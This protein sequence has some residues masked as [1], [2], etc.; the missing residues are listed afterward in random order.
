MSNPDLLYKDV[1]A[2]PRFGPRCLNIMLQSV[3]KATYGYDAE[4]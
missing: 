1:W 4:I 3:F 2:E